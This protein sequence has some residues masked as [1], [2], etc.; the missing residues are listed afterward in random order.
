[1]SA[2]LSFSEGTIRK[3]HGARTS[4]FVEGLKTTYQR[5]HD[6]DQDFALDFEVPEADVK[7]RVNQLRNEAS[8]LNLG[9]DVRKEP[10]SPGMVKI[11]FRARDKRPKAPNGTST[12]ASPAGGNSPSAGPTATA[13]PKAT[14]RKSGK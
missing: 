6:G 9:V 4:D 1:M 5:W 3:S 12:A 14:A 11:S 2:P 7:S 13:E 8:G 10:G